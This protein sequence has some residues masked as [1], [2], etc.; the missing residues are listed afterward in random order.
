MKRF[1]DTAAGKLNPQDLY[2]ARKWVRASDIL[3]QP[4]VLVRANTGKASNGNDCA[5][6]TV[7]FQR[8]PPRITDHNNEPLN[9]YDEY[10][11]SHQGAKII[12]AISHMTKEDFPCGPVCFVAVSTPGGTSKSHELWDYEALEVLHA[13]EM[14]DDNPFMEESPVEPEPE[15]E[16]TNPKSKLD[17]RLYD[18]EKKR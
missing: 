14:A 7:N 12:G 18:R 2:P 13:S 16:R 11:I 5:Y 10:T 4:F 6:L 8:I 17:P 15:P 9:R 1:G 3:E